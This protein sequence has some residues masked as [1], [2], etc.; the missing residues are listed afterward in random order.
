MNGSATGGGGGDGGM[1]VNGG[2][3]A[4][5]DVGS[6]ETLDA[7]SAKKAKKQSMYVKNKLQKGSR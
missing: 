4:H 5:D 3:I 7:R 2:G 6:T 1:A